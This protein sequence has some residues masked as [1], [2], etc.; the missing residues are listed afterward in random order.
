MPALFTPNR[1]SIPPTV[2]GADVKSGVSSPHGND[3]E[4]AGKQ[5]VVVDRNGDIA[6]VL[7]AVLTPQGINV[8]HRSP[9]RSGTSSSAV[10]VAVVDA[11]AEPTTIPTSAEAYVIVGRWRV[12]QDKLPARLAAAPVFDKPFRYPELI[13]AVERAIRKTA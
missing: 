13:A 9:G 3:N 10:H 6:D 11:D 4:S 1:P 2:L 8:G 7:A 12:P 5:V